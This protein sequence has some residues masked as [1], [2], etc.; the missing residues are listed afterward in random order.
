VDHREFRR[1]KRIVKL[2]DCTDRKVQIINRFVTI[3]FRND[4]KLVAHDND[5]EYLKRICKELEDKSIGHDNLIADIKATT[6]SN[7]LNIEL[8]KHQTS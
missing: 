7:T 1:S 5:I 6:E 8:N 4:S 3:L 2:F